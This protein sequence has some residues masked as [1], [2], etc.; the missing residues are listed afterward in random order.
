MFNLLDNAYKFTDENETINI[1]IEKEFANS[2]EFAIITI[3]TLA[4][5]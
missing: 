4:K 3:K 2:K 1:Q 5:E